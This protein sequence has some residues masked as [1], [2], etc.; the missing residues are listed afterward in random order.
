MA[1]DTKKNG[2]KGENQM[3][4]TVLLVLAIAASGFASDT[5]SLAG[6]VLDTQGGAV[7]QA[8]V[9]VLRQ[10]GSAA[11][12]TITGSSGEYRLEGL[13]PGNYVLT[14]DREMFRSATLNVRVT[15]AVISHQDVT[16]EVAGV[17]QSVV[18]TAAAAAQT[19]D[20][21]SKP[22][23][24]ISQ[25]EI[26]NR[27]DYSLTDLLTT[28]PGLYV[29]NEGGPGQ[30]TTISS[31]GLPVDATA[32]LIDGLRFR[33]VASSQADASYFLETMSI[34]NTDHV[35]VMR[36]S[37]SSLYGTDAVG[38]VVNVVTQRGGAPFHGQV[39]LE[40]GSLGMYR[41]RATFGGGAFHDRSAVH[42][43]VASAQ[44]QGRR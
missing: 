18:V 33:D 22:L 42:R 10:D 3:I 41:A 27:N 43:G 26:T 14:V 15:S 20:E 32:I 9:K 2:Y 12:S 25:N 30:Y 4:R 17:N 40:G 31:R 35:E 37:A 29:Q 5:A 1:M 39:Q 16:L 6:R 21:V 24:V 36:G 19:L 7:A 34:I 44:V 38:G 23:D 8:Q 28:T 11:A 13:V